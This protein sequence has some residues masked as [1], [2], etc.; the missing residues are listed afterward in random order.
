MKGIWDYRVVRRTGKDYDGSEWTTYGIYEAYYEGE[1]CKAITAAPVD[2]SDVSVDEL[3]RTLELM[4]VAL[5]RPTLDYE[6][7]RAIRV[8][9]R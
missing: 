4:L 3:R 9:K 5:N 8:R 7:R 6:T 2:V 1:R